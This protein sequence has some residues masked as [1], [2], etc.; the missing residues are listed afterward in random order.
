M[1]DLML[2]GLAVFAFVLW[3]GAGAGNAALWTAFL[4][5]LGARGLGQ[6]ALYPRLTRRTFSAR[7]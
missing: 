6:A 3:L 5:F 2:A 4:I 1:R 7:S